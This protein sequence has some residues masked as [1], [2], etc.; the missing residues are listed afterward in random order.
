MK[1]RKPRNYWTKEKCREDAL[2]Y[3]SRNEFSLYSSI[4]Y[5]TA[6]NNNWLDDISVHMEI[7][8]NRMFRCIYSYEFPDNHVYVGLTHDIKERDSYRKEKIAMLSPNI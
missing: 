1:Q 5:R 3:K 6:L 2:K 4:A 7:F 8:G